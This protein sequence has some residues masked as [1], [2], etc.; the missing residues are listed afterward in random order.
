M[1]YRRCAV[2]DCCKIIIINF[3]LLVIQT[4]QL[5]EVVRWNDDATAHDPLRMRITNRT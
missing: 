5:L 3:V 4:T 1:W 2:D